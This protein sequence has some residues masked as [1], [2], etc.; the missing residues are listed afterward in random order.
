MRIKLFLALFVG[1]VLLTGSAFSANYIYPAAGQSPE[2]QKQDEYECHQWATGQSGYDPIKAAS[3]SKTVTQTVQTQGAPG[4]T[5]HGLLRG[6]ARGA[7][8]A[9]LADG[10]AGKGAAIGGI[11]GAI[12]GAHAGAPK[13][14]QVQVQTS[15]ADPAKQREHDKAKAACLQGRGY[16]VN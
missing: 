10:D 1:G 14:E 3:T 5:G 8:V 4:A 12:R 6:A 15:G 9:G 13:T 11:G 7:L 2:Q 16:T